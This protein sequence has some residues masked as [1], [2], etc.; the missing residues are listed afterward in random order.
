V[1]GVLMGWALLGEALAPS[2]WLSL[3]LVVGGLVLINRRDRAAPGR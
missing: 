3:A 1:A 2:I